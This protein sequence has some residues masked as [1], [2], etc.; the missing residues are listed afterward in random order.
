MSDTPDSNRIPLMSA[1]KA[2]E[3]ARGLKWLA[4]SYA[5]AGMVRDATRAERDRQ[6]WLITQSPWRT[7][8]HTITADRRGDRQ[9][10]WRAAYGQGGDLLAAR[11]ERAGPNGGTLITARRP[12]TWRGHLHPIFRRSCKADANLEFPDVAH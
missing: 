5:D 10:S 3:I 9:H 11:A 6:W 8:R 12:G 1:E 2:Q 4:Q 7:P